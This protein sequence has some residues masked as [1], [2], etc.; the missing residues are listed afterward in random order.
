MFALARKN[1]ISFP[2]K[3]IVIMDWNTEINIEILYEKIVNQFGQEFYSMYIVNMK[4]LQLCFNQIIDESKIK[5]L[6]LKF[7]KIENSPI[8]IQE[9]PE[10]KW[11]IRINRLNTINN[12]KDFPEYLNS[13]KIGDR[14]EILSI[15]FD[16]INDIKDRNNIFSRFDHSKIRLVITILLEKVILDPKVINTYEFKIM[17]FKRFGEIE[18]TL[19]INF[20][21]AD[22]HFEKFMSEI[23]NFFKSIFSECKIL[24]FNTNSYILEERAFNNQFSSDLTSKSSIIHI[25]KCD[26]KP[27]KMYTFKKDAS[28]LYKVTDN[29]L[30][31]ISKKSISKSS[32]TKINSMVINVINSDFKDFIRFSRF[33]H[34]KF[35]CKK[36]VLRI[37]ILISTKLKRDIIFIDYSFSDSMAI[38]F[39][40]ENELRKEI[41]GIEFNHYSKLPFNDLEGNLKLFLNDILDNKFRL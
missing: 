34:D 31:I 25:T 6:L 17:L 27:L 11:S 20:K 4:K 2:L 18:S 5:N 21:G 8:I 36:D 3:F 16:P 35:S 10:R 12:I 40:L 29:Q 28:F 30:R 39:E 14:F 13:I 41:P 38:A 22:E 32:T 33:S 37:G 7:Q 23:N 1:V 19:E 9:Y 24:D 15:P 26:L